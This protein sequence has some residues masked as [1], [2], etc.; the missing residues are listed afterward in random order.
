LQ[1][2]RVFH[3]SLQLISADIMYKKNIHP[4]EIK[5][6]LPPAVYFIIICKYSRLYK[7]IRFISVLECFMQTVYCI[8]YIIAEIGTFWR[9][10]EVEQ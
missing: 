9:C 5:W 3:I 2:V 8:K 1:R 4:D 6:T 7:I 10:K